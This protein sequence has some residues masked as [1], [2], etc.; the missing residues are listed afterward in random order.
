MKYVSLGSHLQVYI[1]CIFFI[2]I[3]Y[4]I[5]GAERG[6]LGQKHC[7]TVWGILR[8]K[9]TTERE[10]PRKRTVLVLH[11]HRAWEELVWIL[12]RKEPITIE[13]A[14]LK[15]P[16][17]FAWSGFRKFCLGSG[18]QTFSLGSGSETCWV[19][20]WLG[21]FMRLQSAL[22]LE[23]HTIKIKEGYTSLADSTLS[24]QRS[25]RKL[26]KHWCKKTSK[27]ITCCL[28]FILKIKFLMC[29]KKK[30]NFFCL[31]VVRFW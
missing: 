2:Y 21:Q 10:K 8:I 16:N 25:I 27:L 12:E 11:T 14:D 13:T 29:L 23:R 26:F 22:R 24:L 30:C 28:C 6:L 4:K 18:F 3:L 31:Q 7:F 15:N 20:G 1:Y 9:L 17:N 19:Q 5:P